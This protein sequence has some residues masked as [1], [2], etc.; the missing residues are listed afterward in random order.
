[1]PKG[2]LS[3]TP[4]ATASTENKAVDCYAEGE[5]AMDQVCATLAV[6]AATD[7]LAE[8][9]LERNRLSERFMEED[10]HFNPP[11]DQVNVGGGDS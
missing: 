9:T 11:G 5:T 7:R 10:F 1:M 6:A 8:A 3:S 4:A 2:S